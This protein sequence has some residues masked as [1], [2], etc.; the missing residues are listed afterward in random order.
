[1]GKRWRKFLYWVS[2]VVTG[3]SSLLFAFEALLMNST[4]KRYSEIYEQF[5]E[6]LS[7]T[8]YTKE[9]A[10]N[11][12]QNTKIEGNLSFFSIEMYKIYFPY[13]VG[14]AIVSAIVFVV[15]IVTHII[16]RK[17]ERNK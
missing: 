6:I 10:T 5:G 7:K 15:I 11:I 16:L 17:K 4:Y 2:L 9:Q 13:V 12:M 1:M 3:L 14:A 8:T